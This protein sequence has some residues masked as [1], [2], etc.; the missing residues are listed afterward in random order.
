MH[1]A[2]IG[3]SERVLDVAWCTGKRRPGVAWHEAA[4][5]EVIVE[6]CKAVES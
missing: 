3:A 5:V 6:G 1:R 4:A 2:G